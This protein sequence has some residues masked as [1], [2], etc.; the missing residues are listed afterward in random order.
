LYFGSKGVNADEVAGVS[1]RV[2]N[3]KRYALLNNRAIRDRVIEL[4]AERFGYDLD[5]VE[6]RLYV[7]K[8][9]GKVGTH[10]V[11]VKE[12]CASQHARGGPIKVVVVDEV[13]A[14]V[15]EVASKSQYRDNAALVALKVLQAAGAL[16]PSETD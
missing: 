6:L 5:Q 3:T 15:R 9:A 16:K 12:W 1:K 8:F 11:R 10:D 14:R 13:V 7:G 4:A 2:S